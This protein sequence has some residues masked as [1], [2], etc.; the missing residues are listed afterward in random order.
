MPQLNFKARFSDFVESGVKRMTIRGRQVELGK[1]LYM[2]TGLRTKASRRLMVRP[3][4]GMEFFTP[5]VP[6]CK[7]CAAI[8]IAET[9]IT[10]AGDDIG[11]RGAAV[12][13]ER[14]GFASWAE[15]RSWFRKTY[16]SLP[17]NGWLIEW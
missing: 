1:P 15:M 4:E 14:D 17:F 13:A 6:L 2:F 16:G 5:G 3:A 12:L 10:L 7:R 8:V 9:G 11:E